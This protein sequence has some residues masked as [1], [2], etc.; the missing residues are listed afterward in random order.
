MSDHRA[1]TI[2]GFK[3]SAVGQLGTEASKFLVGLLLA[4]ILGPEAFGLISIVLVFTGIANI[5]LEFGF[6]EALIQRKE[7]KEADWSTV[8]WVNA[9]TGILLCLLLLGIAPFLAA[10]YEEPQ[11]ENITRVLGGIFL[12][13]GLTVIQRA[14]FSRELQFKLLAKVDVAGFVGSGLLSLLAAWAGWGVWAL[15][16]QHLSRSLIM[17]GM[18]WFMSPWRPRRIFSKASFRESFSFSAYLFVNRILGH[19]SMNADSLVIGK[20]VDNQSLGHYNRAMFTV[21]F[22]VSILTNV[23]TR[24]LFPSLSGIQ[25]NVEQARQLILKITGAMTFFVAPVMSLMVALAAPMVFLLYGGEWMPMVPYLQVFAVLGVASTLS[26]IADTT[27]MS[28]GRKDLIMKIALFEKP[29]VVIATLVGIYWGVWGV[30]VGKLIITIPII[31]LKVKWMAECLGTSGRTVIAPALLPTL[32]A[33]GT[34]L[35]VWL[36]TLVA[37]PVVNTWWFFL[38]AGLAG[39]LL[40]LATQV[41]FRSPDLLMVLRLGSEQGLP[42]PARVRAWMGPGSGGNQP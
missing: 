5:V 2:S 19:L 6:A 10:F 41:L 32:H 1:K 25:G 17:S 37:A 7:V 34:G 29:V 31:W 21:L 27:V 13:Q 11:L 9:G 15:V 26:R 30:L 35:V 39:G 18:L 38:A 20:M 4:R 14:Q 12:F 3:W 33:A 40:Y 16:V 28:M 24:V 23:M 42:L 8:F 22:P 36:T